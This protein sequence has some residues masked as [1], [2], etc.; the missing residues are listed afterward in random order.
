MWSSQ[1]RDGNHYL[2][3]QY[4]S[5]WP[6]DAKRRHRSP[7]TLAQVMACCLTAPSHY[8]NQC[9]LIISKAQWHSAN[10]SFT[11][12]TTAISHWK[13]ENHFAKIPLKAPRGQWV[14]P[15][16][17]RNSWSC[18]QVLVN[19]RTWYE[20]ITPQLKGAHL[21][22]IAMKYR[23]VSNIKTQQIP[24]LKRFSYCLA[25]VFGESLEARCQVENE[26][27]VGAAPTGNAPTTSERSTIFVAY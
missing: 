23:Q 9:W 25:A 13:L 11:W 22:R 26:D 6:G 14:N 8:L 1:E 5:L 21:N 10:S 15:L 2:N 24:T 12:D 18:N 17:T 19:I 27:V 7:S 4:C 3:R 16:M 20:I